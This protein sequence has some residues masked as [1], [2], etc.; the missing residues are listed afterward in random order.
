MRITVSPFRDLH[1]PLR[2]PKGFVVFATKGKEEFNSIF[3]TNELISLDPAVKLP[4]C[5]TPQPPAVKPTAIVQNSQKNSTAGTLRTYRFAVAGSAEYTSYWGDNDDSN[6]N[7]QEDALAA[8]ANTV[9]RM[10]EI[11]LVDLGIQL[12]LV[13]DASMLY[14][15][16]TTDPFEGNFTQEIQTTLTN[17]VGEANY[18]IGHLFHRGVANGDAGVG[19]FAEMEKRGVRFLLTL[20]RQQ[21]GAAALS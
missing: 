11:L 1:G 5:K 14:T 9:N 17:E 3:P 6:G 19:M 18:D 2:T 4:F 16:T 21:M 12:E 13:T 8:V 20:L 10:N 15:D 7:N